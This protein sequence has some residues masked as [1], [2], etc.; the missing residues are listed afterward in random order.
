MKSVSSARWPWIVLVALLVGGLAVAVAGESG[1]RTSEERVRAITESV[2]CPTC[3][4]Q[5]VADSNASAAKSIRTEIARR[6]GE[7]QSD[8]QIRAY[9]DDDLAALYGEDLLL[10]PPKSGVAGL[11]W[12]LPVALFVGAIGGLIGAF[13]YWRGGA[14][15]EVS[16]ADRQLVADAQRRSAP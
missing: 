1:P 10:T 4:G 16:D 6:I 13:R 14:E 7:G 12:F 3:Q 2:K 15:D 11:V 8:E 5:S 9:I